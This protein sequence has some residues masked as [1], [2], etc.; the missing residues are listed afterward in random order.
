MKHLE[1]H[2]SIQNLKV[3]GFV[4]DFE[5][6]SPSLDKTDLLLIINLICK[7]VFRSR[8]KTAKSTHHLALWPLGL[9]QLTEKLKWKRMEREKSY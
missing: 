8:I 9:F 5:S 1:F 6:V 4:S 3:T 2:Y 7:E